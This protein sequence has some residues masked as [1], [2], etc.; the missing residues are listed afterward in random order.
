MTIFQPP[1]LD[2]HDHAMI[3]EITAMREALALNL[4]APRRWIGGLRRTSQAKAVQGSNSIE[5]YTVDHADALAAVDDEPPLSAD[6]ATWHEILGYRRVMTYIVNAATYDADPVDESMLRA[7]HFMLLEH[8][9]S[10]SPGRYRTGPVYVSGIDGVVYTAPDAS[11]V[12]ELMSELV[13]QVQ[14]T[15]EDSLI[16]AAMA[17]LNLVMIH[18]FRDGNGRMARALQTLVLGRDG[19]LEP[20]FSSIEEWLG[21][22]TSD[23]YTALA[24]TGAGAWHPERSAILWVRFNLRAHHMQAQTITRRFAEA[25]KQWAVIDELVATHRLDERTADSIFDAWLGQRITRPAYIHRTGLD[26]RTASRDL[27]K[28]VDEGVLASHGQT[29]GRY[30]DAGPAVLDARDAVR[31][32]RDPLIDPYPQLRGIIAQA[33]TEVTHQSQ[34]SLFG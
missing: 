17:H 6:E 30:Y 10:K 31:R 13:A 5:G 33:A 27:A 14:R 19:V 1:E 12:P 7:M 34:R 29:R 11:D 8:D 28:L 20:A 22:N 16:S 23:Y 15:S 32:S 21:R 26:E 18:P 9:L 2:P 24:A 4:R 3:D 25:S